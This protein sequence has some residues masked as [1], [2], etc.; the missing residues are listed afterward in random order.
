M[1]FTSSLQTCR[2]SWRQH[3]VA[4]RLCVMVVW[5]LAMVL[6]LWFIPGSS[7]LLSA[8]PVWAYWLVAHITPLI[9]VLLLL[10]P[11]EQSAQQ[12]LLQTSYAALQ[13]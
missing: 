7:S 13:V 11:A 5:T 4:W 10:L 12:E 6:G 3:P 9:Y 2:K 1:S 8:T